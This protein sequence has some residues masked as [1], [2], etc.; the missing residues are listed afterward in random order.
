MTTSTSNCTS[1]H[2]NVESN[3]LQSCQNCNEY[4]NDGEELK[5]Q[6]HA[7]KQKMLN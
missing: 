6:V 4:S 3:N 1:T 2:D 7:L 5:I